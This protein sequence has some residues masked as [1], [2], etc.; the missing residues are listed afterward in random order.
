MNPSTV[1]QKN[2]TTAKGAGPSLLACLFCRQR[3]LKCDG[4]TPVCGRC[5]AS[6]TECQ[7]TPSRRGYKGPSKKRRA[8]PTSPELMPTELP[9]AEPSVDIPG[10]PTDWGLP[11]SLGYS[12]V[13]PLPSTSSTSPNLNELVSSQSVRLTNGPLTPESSSSIQS[14]G[15]LVDIYYTYFHP[16]H[17]ILPPLHLLYRSY[18]PPYL[19]HVIKFIGSH[20]TPAAN[21]EVYRPTVKSSVMEQDGT[22]EK[23]QALLLLAIVLH[24]RNERAE[25]GECLAVAVELTFQ[26]GLNRGDAAI[27]MGGGDPVREESL[28]RTWWEMFIIEGML[29]ALGVQRVFRCNSLPLEVPL[30]CEDRIYQ[31]GLPAPPPPTIQQFDERIFADEERDF[32]SSCYR[33]EAIRILGRVVAVQDMIEG[34]QDHVESIDARVTSWFHHLPESKS[35]L[36]RP[37]GSVDEMMFQAT[38]IVNGASIYLHFPRSDLLSSPTVAA[39]VI[40]GHHGPCS[41]PAFSHQ[42]HAMK[43]VKAASELSSLASIRLPVVKHTPF[44]ICA[45]VLSSIVQLAACSVKAGQMPDPSRDRLTLTIGVFK[46]LARTW[47][48]SQSIMRQIKAVARDVMDV[49]LRPSLD[50]IDLTGVLDN[51]RFWPQETDLLTQ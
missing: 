17:P 5:A 9:S 44:F 35:E 24:S 20:F 51:N 25:A 11:T 15:Y 32:S 36:L 8:N 2:A 38:M 41:V 34:Q 4:Q 27:T 30:P 10:L 1:P 22:V 45:L 43:A 48:I 42:A 50:H 37:D 26:L 33:I 3:H 28:R 21:S 40:C 23:A 47:A 13:A 49:G 19:D 18:V 29:T 31:N 12:S 7:Y 14:D 16:A 6:G 39:E 46:S